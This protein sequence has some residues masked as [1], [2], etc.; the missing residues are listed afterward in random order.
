MAASWR[1]DS[2]CP[3]GRE[4]D[5]PQSTHYTRL[6][7]SFLI[8]CAL[9]GG[10]V[11]A[12]SIDGLVV[13]VAD[14][15]TITILDDEHQQHRIRL[16]GIDAPEMGQDF[17]RLSK[18][19]LSDLV[20]RQHVQVDTEKLDRYG[21]VVGKVTVYGQDVNLQQVRRGMAWHY[22]AYQREQSK[23]DRLAYAAAEAAA[24]T[25]RIGLWAMPQPQV[26]PWT[27]RAARPP[28]Q[29]AGAGESIK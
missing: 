2:R 1:C 23:A 4:V 5:A 14:G 29:T 7:K 21:R 24:R 3:S 8:C 27:F 19:S 12:A 17:G 25:G 13:S 6:A 9:A 20:Y 10:A 22:K 16:A 18:G 15:D 28:R 26:P 11:A